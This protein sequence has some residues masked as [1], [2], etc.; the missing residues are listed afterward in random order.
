MIKVTD[1][2]F[3]E[4]QKKL[5]TPL[6]GRL[7]DFVRRAGN[8]MET[9]AKKNINAS[10]YQS[11]VSPFYDRTG[12]AQQSIVMEMQSTL[13]ARVFMGVDYGKYLEYGTGIYHTPDARTPWFTSKIPGTNGKTVYIKGMKA[14]P[15]WHPAIDS[16]REFIQANLKGVD[17]IE[18]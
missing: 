7:S 12:K 1:T 5:D 10:V 3:I 17:L 15:F 18:K 16:T 2:G 13:T 8:E 9:T 4:L 14:R 11:E 6:K